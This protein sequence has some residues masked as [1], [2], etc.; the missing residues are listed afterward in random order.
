VQQLV[1]ILRVTEMPWNER[2]SLLKMGNWAMP[3]ETP[4]LALPFSGLALSH[5]P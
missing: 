3:P 4:S 2:R 5:N 1:D